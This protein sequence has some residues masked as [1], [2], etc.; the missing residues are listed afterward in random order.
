MIVLVLGGTRS[1][2]SGV[3][4]SVAESL[5]PV[6][7]YV[8]PAALDGKDADFAVRVAAHQARRPAH[9]GTVECEAPEDMPRFLADIE[10]VA[11]IDSL[12]TWVARHSDLAVE[13]DGLLD[14]LVRRT[15]PVVIVSEEVGLSVHAPTES[16]RR[17]ADALGLLNQRVAAA[18]DRGVGGVAGR[19]REVAGGAG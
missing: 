11:L 10:G 6:V 4:E 13:A 8:A 14:A 16:G 18:A 3:A 2:K 19:V 17:F 9:W 12:G 7:T 5:G 1:G 15:D